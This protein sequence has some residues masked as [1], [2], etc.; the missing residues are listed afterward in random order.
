MARRGVLL[1]VAVLAAVLLKA[2]HVA[3][4][5]FVSP[6]APLAPAPQH[7]LQARSPI[8][9][10]ARGGGEYDVSD[11]DIEAFYAETITGGGGNPPKG[12]VTAE[13]IVKH[14]YG[15]FT[16]QG[17]KRYSGMWMGPPRGTIGNKD[18]AEGMKGLQ[19][20]MKNPM[21]VTKGG[22][23]YGVDE[24]QKVVDDGK[25]WV[26]LAA[27]MSPG[28]LAVE[29]FKSVP[30]GKRALLV[31]KQSN[32]DEMFTKVNWD[33]MNKRIDTTLGGPKVVQR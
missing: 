33:L 12:T 19:E 18:I 21:Y 25:G 14:F 29:L 9:L 6:A 15:E 32:I 24:T 8:S 30:Y 3:L 7:S 17:F 11:A 20:Q 4:Q 2:S 27:D 22:V 10:R 31:A 13:L 16:P 26:W 5:S 28:G 23:G 1:P